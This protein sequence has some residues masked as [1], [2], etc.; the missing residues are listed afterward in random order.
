M[1]HN[2]GGD[3]EDQKG[4]LRPSNPSNAIKPKRTETIKVRLTEA[5]WND[6]SSPLK[7]NG[8]TGRGLSKLIRDRLFSSSRRH[9]SHPMNCKHCRL[10][11]MAVNNLN[12]IARRVEGMPE[13]EKAIEIL[14]HLK[15][16]EHEIQKQTGRKAA[17]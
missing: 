1:A 2:G 12:I 15:S 16:L 6:L 17:E 3:G 9:A 5:E 11:A 7:Y 13:P 4:A 10:L 14:V 8:K